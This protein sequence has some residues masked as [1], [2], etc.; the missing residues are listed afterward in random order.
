MVKLG[1]CVVALFLLLLF[2]PV[3]FAIL[4]ACLNPNVGR[5]R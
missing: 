2:G 3:G 5:R 4:W 1:C